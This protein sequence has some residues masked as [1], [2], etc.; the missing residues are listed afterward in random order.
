PVAEKLRELVLD[1]AHD[2]SATTEALLFAAARADHLDQTIRPALQAGKIV[3]S[4]RFVGSSIAYQAAGRGLSQDDIVGMNRY[5]TGG[6]TP[7]LTV[8]L[9]LTEEVAK[10]RRASRGQ[11]VDRMEAAPDGFQDAVRA[12][13]LEQAAAAP[14]R[15]LVVDA[16]QTA[17]QIT[18]EILG[19]LASH[20]EVHC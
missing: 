9:D 13:F 8:V 20:C 12:S 19:Y 11:D 7:H 2:I 14:Q 4:D 3:I 16:G 15:H 5:A 6:L 10:R 1:P 18:S 17:E